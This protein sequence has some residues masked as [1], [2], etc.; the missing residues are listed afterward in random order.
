MATLTLG[1]GV[2]CRAGAV[3]AAVKGAGI[4]PESGDLAF[5]SAGCTPFL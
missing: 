5:R 4:L 1:H 2:S 3:K